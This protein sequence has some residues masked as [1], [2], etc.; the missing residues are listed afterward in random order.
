[1][2]DV[3]GLPKQFRRTNVVDQVTFA[4]CAGEITSYLGPNGSGKST[5]VKC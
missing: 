5:T 2:L 4:I 3:H 1:M